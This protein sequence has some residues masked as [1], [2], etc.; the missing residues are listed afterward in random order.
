MEGVTVDDGDTEAMDTVAAAEP[1]IDAVPLD[2]ADASA[3][4]EL[5][6]VEEGEAV[7]AGELDAEDVDADEAVPVRDGAEGDI[8]LLAVTFA[9]SD[10]DRVARPLPDAPALDVPGFVERALEEALRVDDLVLAG[11]DEVET[12]SD[13]DRVGRAERLRD[14]DGEKEDVLRADA[15]SDTD[16]D[17]HEVS[18]ELADRS[19]DAEGTRDEEDT[20]LALG[21]SVDM[22]DADATPEASALIE[23]CDD[24]D[25]LDEALLVDLAE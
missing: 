17:A 20:R 7:H 12:D 18:E 9:V 24:I 16:L 19:A 2:D 8:W 1:V 5:E 15:D 22:N 6:K 23:T 14:G 10:D 4:L 25:K 3:V 21:V 11:D 13:A